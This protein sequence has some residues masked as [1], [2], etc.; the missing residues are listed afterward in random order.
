MGR[1]DT[2][3]VLVSQNIGQLS[4]NLSA[5]GEE[6]VTGVTD[7]NSLCLAIT[8]LLE[9]WRAEDVATAANQPPPPPLP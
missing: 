5:V 4:R 8:A 6:P 3:K 2:G 9:K 1:D 7:V